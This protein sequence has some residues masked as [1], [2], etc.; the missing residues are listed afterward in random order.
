MRLTLPLLIALTAVVAGL[1]ALPNAHAA[2]FYIETLVP[3]ADAGSLA[4]S[5]SVKEGV[6][7]MVR[8]PS[9]AVTYKL[10]ETGATCSATANDSV[11]DSDQS[12]D[13]CPL[14]G[15]S[16]L[17][18]FRTYDAGNPSCKVYRVNPPSP[19]CKQ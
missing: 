8:C 10:C 7:L 12:I 5:A 17:S 1:W 11:I 9:Y 19:Q 2:D 15:Y 14:T 4:N 18:V 6:Q 16:K 13:I 3:G